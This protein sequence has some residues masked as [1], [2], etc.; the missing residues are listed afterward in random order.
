MADRLQSSQNL[1]DKVISAALNYLNKNDFDIYTNPNGN[2]NVGIGNNYPDIILTKKGTNTVSFI[3]EVETADSITSNEATN[4]WKK[5][6]SEITSSFYLL[7]PITHKNLASDF[8]RQVG[9]SVRFATFTSD[10]YGNITNITF[11]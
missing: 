9:I 11:E 6:A 8:C 2:H 5:Y 10:N 4:Q 3:I 7:V 1:H